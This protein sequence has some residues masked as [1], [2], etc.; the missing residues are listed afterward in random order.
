[1]L[2][3]LEYLIIKCFLY[4]KDPDGKVVIA[5]CSHERQSLVTLEIP[6]RSADCPEVEDDTEET[7]VS[8]RKDDMEVPL[9]P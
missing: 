5:S 6:E 7:S 4:L 8:G 1:V 3:T 9:I 2:F